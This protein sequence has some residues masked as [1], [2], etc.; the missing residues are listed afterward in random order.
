AELAGAAPPPPDA[1]PARD[2]AARRV[3]PAR[4]IL[5]RGGT[6]LSMDGTVGDFP[7]GDVLIE[8]SRI[9]AVAPRIEAEATVVDA[10]DMIVLPGFCDPHI[11]CWQGALGR[12]I[13]NNTSTHDEESGISVERP[14]ATRSYQNVL[15]NIFAPVYRPEDMYIGTLLTLAGAIS[16]GITT[17]CDNAHNSRSQAHSDACVAALADSGIR[18]IHAYGR[19]RSG[20]WDGQFPRDIYRLRERYFSSDDQLLGLR[21][22]MLGRDSMEELEEIVRIRQDL[23]LW[24]SFDSGIGGKPL[25]DLYGRGWFDGRETINHGNFISTE[26]RRLIVAHGTQVNVCPRIEAQF[27]FGHIPYQDWLDSGLRPAI[28]ND[29]P[30]TYAINTFSEMQCLYAFQRARVLSTRV[31]ADQGP[32]V[33]ATLREMLE[34]VTIRGAENCGLAHKVGS[35]TPGKEADI[36][37]IDT[38]TP[39]LTPMNNAYCTA[40]QGATVHD[41]DTVMIGGRLAKWRGRLVGLDVAAI[42]RT[43]LASRDALFQAVGWPLEAIDVTD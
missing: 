1:P 42:R 24:I 17:V 4:R 33:L 2:P 6:V 22:Y 3:D 5:L 13:P 20:A 8:G 35:L 9:A 31:G 18:G 40:V 16:G 7:V 21:L 39:L 14:H 27:R 30:A 19:P 23:D 41:V 38:R 25:A 43:A 29:D 26:Q 37:M 28:S 32:P 34:A 36:V 10:T 12:L 15:H 11:H